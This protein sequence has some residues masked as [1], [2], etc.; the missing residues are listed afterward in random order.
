MKDNL[1]GGMHVL[2]VVE[3]LSVPFDRRV[4]RE[5]CALH[6]A[7]ADISVICPRGKSYDTESKAEIDGIRI[8][9]YNLPLEGISS[10]S[11]FTVGSF[12]LEYFLALTKTFLLSLKIYYGKR[13]QV[14][15]VA[16]PPD[17]F[18]LIGWCYK[19]IGVKFV[20]DHHDVCPEGYLDK[21]REP[22]PDILYRAQV[23]L[24][25]LSFRTANVVISTNE[26]YK[27]IAIRRGKKKPESVFVV[28]NGPDENGW[29]NMTKRADG[30]M[31][32]EYLVGY[33]GVM[34]KLDGVDFVVRAADYIVNVAGRKNV[35][36][37]LIGSGT[38][39]DELCELTETL[40]LTNHVRF[41]GRI[42]DEKVFEIL[43]SID[44]G[45]SP[46]P[47]GLLNDIS[48]MN[49]V[50]DYMWF[51]KPIVSFELAESR[52]SA[53]D[54]AVYVKDVT[55]VALGKAIL[56]LIDNPKKREIMGAS[57][58]Q[59]VRHL[60]WQTSKKNLLSAY[61]HMVKS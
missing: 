41:T 9:R 27:E 36:F 50:M 45:V 22:K 35:G 39:Y 42:P 16:N 43:S 26:S 14:I 5:A 11:R 59:R 2:M 24:E 60:T 44:V 20:F 18:F 48:T 37:V 10:G 12:L 15:H 17:I 58:L 52:I 8:Y 19:P 38:S 56:E 55:H 33:I 1:F 7:G 4:W 30:K 28:R 21:K 40:S 46:D 23:L 6:E 53:Q 61:Q 32:F 34:A 25:K 47:P 54:A 29:P 51:G 49:K 13:F 57:G 31:G 3:N